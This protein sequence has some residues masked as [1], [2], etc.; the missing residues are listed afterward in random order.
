M[1]D[2][3]IYMRSDDMTVSLGTRLMRLLSFISTV[4]NA[5]LTR[6]RTVFTDAGWSQMLWTILKNTLLRSV[7]TVNAP[8]LIVLFKMLISGIILFLDS[9]GTSNIRNA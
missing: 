3:R 6:W 8:L 5:S 9:S 7:S 2:L 4:F 1:G